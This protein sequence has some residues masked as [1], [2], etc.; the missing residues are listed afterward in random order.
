MQFLICGLLSFVTRKISFERVIIGKL[1][2][3]A[4][5]F[6]YGH[7]VADESRIAGYFPF[8]VKTPTIFIHVLTCTYTVKLFY[9]AGVVVSQF[10][11]FKFVL[12]SWNYSVYRKNLKTKCLFYIY[13]HVCMLVCFCK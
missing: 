6:I 3:T 4:F 5:M 10:E 8:G 13:L 1:H 2:L 9:V 7:F 11:T 12:G